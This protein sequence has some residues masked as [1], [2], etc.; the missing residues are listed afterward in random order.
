MNSIQT[1]M[2]AFKERQHV[3]FQE[4]QR[5]CEVQDRNLEMFIERMDAP[6]W[7]EDDSAPPATVAAVPPSTHPR[8]CLS[9]ASLLCIVPK[10]LTY[11][12]SCTSI[13]L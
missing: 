3:H 7:N 12:W 10:L 1:Q 8:V 2:A 9:C 11:M 4:L 5:Q 13:R 6:A